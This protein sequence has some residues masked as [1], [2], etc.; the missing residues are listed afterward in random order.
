MN[1]TLTTTRDF[2]RSISESFI[3]WSVNK[4]SL[5]ILLFVSIFILITAVIHFFLTRIARKKAKKSE[6]L[7]VEP[8]IVSAILD[9]ALQ[10][11]STFLVSLNPE[12]SY[13][14]KC[15]IEDIISDGII[16]ELPT[17]IKNVKQQIIGRK[18]YVT[19]SVP[20]KKQRIFYFFS[21]T[22]MSVFKRDKYIF[23]RIE[24]PSWLE[25]RQKRNFLRIEV[26]SEDFEDLIIWKEK[27]LPS[28][29]L[30]DSI[31]RLGVPIY[32]KREKKFF[33]VMDIS[34]LGIRLKFPIN[35][36]KV[37][38]EELD[39]GDG[40]II[41]FKLNGGKDKKGYVF[42]LHGSIRN[43]Y[44]DPVDKYVEFGI[45]FE[46]IGKYEGDEKKIVWEKIDPKI[47]VRELSD[48]VMQKHLYYFRKGV[49]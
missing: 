43:K 12:S 6:F 13:S 39:K 47:G 24:F 17:Y 15:S 32:K 22:I 11:R 20:Y 40:F 10:D 25:L 31:S 42:L 34:G 45:K 37:F 26:S 4:T 5:F 18:A 41:F 38:T 3:G 1:V 35:Y 44:K 19:F 29:I 14:L 8:S 48:W 27:F 2:F 16:L 30:V 49:A 33:P 9:Q 23:I 28:G 21:S 36:L 7:I 46:N